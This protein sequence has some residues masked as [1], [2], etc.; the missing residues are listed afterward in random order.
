MNTSQELRVGELRVEGQAP[1]A[2]NTAVRAETVASGVPDQGPA[3]RA[4]DGSIVP[5]V[6]EVKPG[7]ELAIAG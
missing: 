1:I 3:I 5:A 2:N 4:D 6:V 7:R